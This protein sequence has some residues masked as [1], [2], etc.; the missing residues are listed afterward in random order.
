MP[1]TGILVAFLVLIM[2]LLI[3]RYIIR[4]LAFGVIK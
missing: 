1:T 4:G 2:T 3:Q